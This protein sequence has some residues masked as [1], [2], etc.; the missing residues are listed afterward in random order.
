M[1]VVSILDCNSVHLIRV[2]KS[3]SVG[4]PSSAHQN[5]MMLLGRDHDP[6]PDILS[7]DDWGFSVF[8]LLFSDAMGMALS[9]PWL[10]TS[11]PK[12]EVL[13]PRTKSFCHNE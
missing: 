4:S 7:D 3:R 1:L 8:L 5:R 11:L 12:L 9:S 6:I 2:L 13:T 10:V